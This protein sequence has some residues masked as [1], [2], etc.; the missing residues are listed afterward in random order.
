MAVF[1][2]IIQMERNKKNFKDAGRKEQ[3]EFR[4]W[5]LL[6]SEKNFRNFL[7]NEILVL[8]LNYLVYNEESKTNSI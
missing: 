6:R 5:I 8:L 1:W 7:E 4:G 3:K 2:A